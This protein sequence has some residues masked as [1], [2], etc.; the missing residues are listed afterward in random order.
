MA[1]DSW[2]NSP[3][4][5]MALEQG[6]RYGLTQG[7]R[8]LNQTMNAP[9]RNTTRE[10][11]APR[12]R[13]SVKRKASSSKKLSLKRVKI[14]RA[15]KFTGSYRRYV[16][17]GYIGKFRKRTRQ[18]KAGAYLTYGSSKK[19]EIGGSIDSTPAG[20]DPPIDRRVLY[21]G[22][23]TMNRDEI[24]ICMARAVTR[25]ACRMAKMDFTAWSE[26]VDI[27]NDSIYFTVVFFT[28]LTATSPVEIPL[29][30]LLAT[31]ASN[32][33]Q[34]AESLA[35]LIQQSTNLNFANEDRKSVV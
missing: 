34:L 25:K 23:S 31:A 7:A 32:Y 29:V 9:A 16:S 2:M 3:A 8:W 11:A 5:Q 33:Q 18:A 22:H 28:N 27:G 26:L 13:K 10:V 30:P 19:K 1:K 35:T 20:P 4:V 14:P 21:I 6:V 12:M 17:R 24:H 15:P